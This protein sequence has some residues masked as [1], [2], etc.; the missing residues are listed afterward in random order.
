MKILPY[1]KVAIIV[2]VLDQISKII[3]RHYMELHEVI[4]IT[5]SFFWLTYVENTGAAFSMSFGSELFNRIFFIVVSVL[6]IL[7]IIYMSKKS[8]SKVEQVAFAMIIGGA[9]GNLIDRILIGS[10]TDF[11]W[12]DFFDF[13][14]ERWPVF[15]L[16]DSAIVVA[17]VLI[18][19]KAVFDSNKKVEEQ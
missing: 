12:W 16:A 11:I 7:L 1:Y 19:I 3:V 5:D 13:I 2:I 9:I 4:K 18:V 10:V 15:N 6:I 14:M 8:D 17:V